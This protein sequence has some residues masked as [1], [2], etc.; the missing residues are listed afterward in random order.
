MF[1][2]IYIYEAGALPNQSKSFLRPY[3]TTTVAHGLLG[4]KQANNQNKPNFPPK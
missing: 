1:A 4:K 2:C 3:K